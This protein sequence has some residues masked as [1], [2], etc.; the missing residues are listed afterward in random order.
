MDSEWIHFRGKSSSCMFSR[1]DSNGHDA[2]SGLLL[3]ARRSDRTRQ[4]ARSLVVTALHFSLFRARRSGTRLGACESGAGWTRTTSA[5]RS[6]QPRPLRQRSTTERASTHRRASTPIPPLLRL[7]PSPPPPHLAR[8]SP[9]PPRRTNPRNVIQTPTSTTGIQTHTTTQ[10]TERS[11]MRST[12]SPP[13]PWRTIS[14]SSPFPSSTVA[15][16]SISAE[17]TSKSWPREVRY[18]ATIP[19]LCVLHYTGAICRVDDGIRS[20]NLPSKS[21]DQKF[22]TAWTVR[23]ESRSLERRTRSPRLREDKSLSSQRINRVSVSDSKRS[24]MSRSS[25]PARTRASS[26]LKF[27]TSSFSTSRFVC[28][29]S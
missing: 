24:G 13:T 25:S 22:S 3:V 23:N 28:R 9:S 29:S 10:P 5:S 12:S 19:S 15:F 27:D 14:V 21:R 26:K 16:I 18:Y 11:T 2:S 1:F 8:L 20:G 17:A 7:R 6:A 4:V